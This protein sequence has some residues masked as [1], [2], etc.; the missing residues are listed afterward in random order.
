MKPHDANGLAVHVEAHE[1]VQGEVPGPGPDPGEVRVAVEGHD[2]GNG[3]FC[4]GMRR[5]CRNPHDPDPELLCGCEINVV[6]SG[7]AQRDKTD[8][9]ILKD[10]EDFPVAGV[11]DEYAHRLCACSQGCVL[12]G[13][14]AA[15]VQYLKAELS[16]DFLEHFPVIGMGSVK[17]YF[18]Q[19]SV[20]LICR[21]LK[22]G[23]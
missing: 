10:P 7:A 2:E 17:G 9:V 3:V 13:E 5:V 4:D 14:V 15:V 16:V 23:S 1:S 18:V 22:S 12:R 20:L 11:V 19:L 6:E 8:T 21:L